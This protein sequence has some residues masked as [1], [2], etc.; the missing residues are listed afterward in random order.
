MRYNYLDLFRLRGLGGEAFFIKKKHKIDPRRFTKI[1]Q[2][3]LML[4]IGLCFM[5]IHVFFLV[6]F[7]L[8]GIT[9][10]FVFNIFSVI[11]YAMLAVLVYTKPN[12]VISYA[13][14]VMTE[15]LLHAVAATLFTGWFSGFPM[16]IVCLAPFPFFLDFKNDITPI[17]FETLIVFSFLILKLYTASDTS[18]VYKTVANDIT[19]TLF[20]FNTVVSFMMMI[21]FSNIYKVVRQIDRINLKEQNE[22][23]SM[24]AKI[25]PLSKLFNRRAMGEFLLMTEEKCKAEGKTYVIVM[26]DLD[27]FKHINDTYGH[28]TGDQVI[29]TVSQIMTD[30]VPA[31]GYVCR[32]GG[33]ELLFAVPF[34]DHFKGKEIAEG[35]LS[36]LSEVDFNAGGGESFKVTAT[37][38]VCECDCSFSYERAVS[39]ADEYLYCGKQHG[40]NTVV[41][42]EEFERQRLRNES[43]EKSVPEKSIPEK[44]AERVYEKKPS[45][46]AR[47]RKGSKLGKRK[48]S[49]V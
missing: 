26:C 30:Q 29:K 44:S 49:R 16:F 36:K 7:F 37:F 5:V 13:C 32:W 34:A 24:L 20:I 27:D 1:P 21:I 47:Q 23:L 42:R 45:N 43:A 6:Y 18:L 14:A 11:F 35:I 4:T 15:I 3:K 25:D 9:E 17:S 19:D 10:M 28:N 33:E 8:L 39:I 41:G 40:K 38:G 48:K 22:E 2:N 46:E 12:H 31:E